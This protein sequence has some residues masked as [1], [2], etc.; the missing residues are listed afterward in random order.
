MRMVDVLPSFPSITFW[1]DIGERVRSE[2]FGWPIHSGR[3]PFT[4]HATNAAAS[5]TVL[6]PMVILVIFRQFD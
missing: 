4:A 3:S 6:Y 1:G 5:D 2:V